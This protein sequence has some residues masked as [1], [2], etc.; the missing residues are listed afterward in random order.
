MC[1][2][3][4][5]GD[6]QGYSAVMNVCHPGLYVRASERVGLLAVSNSAGDGGSSLAVTSVTDW[7]HGKFLAAVGQVSLALH[8]LL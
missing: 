2:S 3:Y 5:G 4:G 8:E 7:E 6:G 1:R